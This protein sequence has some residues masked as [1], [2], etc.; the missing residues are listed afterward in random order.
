[1]IQPNGLT[2][3]LFAEKQRTL[4][5]KLMN[6][7]RNTVITKNTTC[8]FIMQMLENMYRCTDWGWSVYFWTTLYKKT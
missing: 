4:Q 7:I 2:K 3:H 8:F 5:Y 1:M 6:V